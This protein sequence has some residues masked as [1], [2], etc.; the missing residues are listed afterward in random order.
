MCWS[1]LPTIKKG[2][3][4]PHLIFAGLQNSGLF[5]QICVLDSPG[6]HLGKLVGSLE[7]KASWCQA[8]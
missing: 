6:L 1:L 7:H 8:W 3:S 2:S 5:L 4:I